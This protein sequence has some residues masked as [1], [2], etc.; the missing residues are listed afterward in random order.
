MKING[1][2]ISFGNTEGELLISKIP[3]SFFGMVNVKDGTIIDKNN[4]LYGNSI[5]DKILLFPHGCGSTVGSY[6]IYQLKMNNVAP[7]GIINL[8]CETIIAVG[9]IMSNI[10]LI[11]KLEKN[12]Y[13]YVNNGD[14]VTIN[15]NDSCIYI[16]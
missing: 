16:E 9:S 7:K 4:E 13:L 3:I 15:S 14:I 5:K 1:R 12:P 8:E 10:P 6:S 11:D 2:I